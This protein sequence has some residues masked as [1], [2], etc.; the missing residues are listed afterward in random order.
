MSVL[1]RSKRGESAGR[2]RR[3]RPARRSDER[4]AATATTDV[5]AGSDPALSAKPATPGRRRE[6]GPVQDQ[7]LYTCE[8]GFVF[9][10]AVSTS[11]GCPHCGGTQAW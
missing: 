4:A 9:K 10:A 7:A 6:L 11:V 3:L 5:S 2:R 1:V 8:C